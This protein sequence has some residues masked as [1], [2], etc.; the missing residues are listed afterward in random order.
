GIGSAQDATTRQTVRERP[1]RDDEEL[2]MD[3]AV[4]I[5][6]G[7]FHACALDDDGPI[8]C[9]GDDAAGQLGADPDDDEDE[10]VFGRAV[11]VER[12]S[13]GGGGRGP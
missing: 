13:F 3:D 2:Y 5:A 10:R 6:A 12:F 9:W 1:D 11:R 7:A 4:A 8:D